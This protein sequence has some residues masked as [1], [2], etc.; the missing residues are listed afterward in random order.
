M[1][2]PQHN[3]PTRATAF[4]DSLR[5]DPAANFPELHCR[6]R[7]TKAEAEDVLAWLEAHGLRGELSADET[8]FFVCGIALATPEDPCREDAVVELAL[9]LPRRQLGE[10]ETA[11]TVEGLSA[12]QLIRR[13]IG[14]YLRARAPAAVSR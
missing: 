11:A 9:L 12:G 2:R 1:S 14:D 4:P 8:G 7:L 6:K 5:R 13:L 3:P 10:L